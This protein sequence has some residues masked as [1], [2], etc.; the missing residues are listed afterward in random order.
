MTALQEPVRSVAYTKYAPLTPETLRLVL[1]NFSQSSI[2]RCDAE[3]S[4]GTIR[5]ETVT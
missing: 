2:V 3:K 1:N 4:L 5:L